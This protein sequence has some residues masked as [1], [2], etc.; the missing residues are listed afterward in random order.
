MEIGSAELDRLLLSFVWGYQKKYGSSFYNKED[1]YCEAR[2]AAYLAIKNYKE[3][4]NTK[5]KTYIITCIKNHFSNLAR[6]QRTSKIIYLQPKDLL[7]FD[8]PKAEN[9]YSDFDFHSTLHNL[10][11]YEEFEI[12]QMYL[13]DGYTLQEIADLKGVEIWKAHRDFSRILQKYKSHVENL[14]S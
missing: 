11:S 13:V 9:T 8:I 1:L 10:L 2:L 3:K 7:H 4:K 5:L 14:I 6:K 12:Y